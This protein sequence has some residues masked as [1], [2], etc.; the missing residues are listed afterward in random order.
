MKLKEQ[1]KFNW[2]SLLK[3]E[4]I[5]RREPY[6][7]NKGFE[8]P[9]FKPKDSDSE[10]RIVNLLCVPLLIENQAIGV[11]NVLNKNW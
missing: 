11:I 4:S 1:L 2:E 6:I 8:D 9:L 3:G 10:S 7:S 5:P